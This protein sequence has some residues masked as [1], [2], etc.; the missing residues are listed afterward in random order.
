MFSF[1]FVIE[2]IRYRSFTIEE[3]VLSLTSLLII[4]E[5]LSRAFFATKKTRFV[6]RCFECET[7][8]HNLTNIWI[9]GF[10]F[11][12]L[13]LQH[14]LSCLSSYSPS[15][16][17][18]TVGWNDLKKLGT[19][20]VVPFCCFACNPTI[21]KK[22]LFLFLFNIFKGCTWIKMW[23]FVCL[24]AKTVVKQKKMVLPSP[25]AKN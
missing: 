13:F 1:R 18:N 5:R 12:S 9:P 24:K 17:L 3:L 22:S 25:W 11:I 14:F 8:K 10:F 4:M 20:Q 15:P 6:G 21:S 16:L 19:W 7:F 2:T 23:T